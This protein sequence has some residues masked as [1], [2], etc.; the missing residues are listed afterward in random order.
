MK[1]IVMPICILILMCDLSADGYLGKA[2]SVSP[3]SPVKSL[4]VSSGHF[5]SGAPDSHHEI[6]PANLHLPFSHC[7]GQPLKLFV[8][9]S[10]KEIFTSNLSRA[11]GLPWYLPGGFGHVEENR[12]IIDFGS[13]GDAVVRG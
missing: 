11:G 6:L 13:G 4:Q 12:R 10:R 9:Q 2:K 7:C 5:G 1:R 3:L 8:Q